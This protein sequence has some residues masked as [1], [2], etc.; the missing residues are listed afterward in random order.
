MR[1]SSKWPR[2]PTDGI[3][4]PDVLSDYLQMPH[5]NLLPRA[6]MPYT[7][8]VSQSPGDS[9]VQGHCAGMAGLLVRALPLM[10]MAILLLWS[11][12]A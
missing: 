2:S 10:Q 6:S 1:I 3:P 9:E 11:H 7:E 12:M 5:E 4:F 8:E